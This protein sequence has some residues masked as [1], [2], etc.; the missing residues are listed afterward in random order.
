MIL[1][2]SAL[3]A[4]PRRPVD[5][6]ALESRA[7]DA[8]QKASKT[9]LVSDYELAIAQLD[10]LLRSRGASS[11]LRYRAALYKGE[12][13]WLLG[14]WRL[15]I[16]SYGKCSVAESKYAADCSFYRF[17]AAQQSHK[18]TTVEFEIDGLGQRRLPHKPI[19]DPSKKP[20]LSAIAAA[21]TPMPWTQTAEDVLLVAEEHRQLLASLGS[22]AP[23]QSLA[24]TARIEFDLSV[25]LLQ[26][27]KVDQAR[28][29]FVLA[30]AE[31]Q[32]FVDTTG[33]PVHALAA[34]F[35]QLSAL[36]AKRTTKSVS[37]AGAPQAGMKH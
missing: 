26:H 5:L 1:G 16:G 35:D 20:R 8:F 31:W 30:K 13:A 2:A 34:D 15:A 17:L 23:P 12:A 10:F 11:D 22:R 21:A 4:E 37:P 18:A 14:R 36:L 27:G 33:T 7:F 24:R 29:H 28:Q 6:K 9:R 32:Q 25:L 19:L 3:N